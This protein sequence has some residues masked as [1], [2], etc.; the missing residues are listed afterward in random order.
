MLV[1]ITYSD[2]I[3][4]FQEQGLA[5]G[6]AMAL[7]AVFG[8]G[9]QTYKTDQS[10]R[11]SELGYT[12]DNATEAWMDYRDKGEVADRVTDETSLKKEVR[13]FVRDVLLTDHGSGEVAQFL[14]ASSNDDKLELAE[15]VYSDDPAKW[16][17]F[18]LDLMESKRKAEE[19]MAAAYEYDG[20]Q[21]PPKYA[22]ISD[23]LW[24]KMPEEMQS[25]IAE[26]TA[27]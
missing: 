16:R 12:G 9:I 3:E 22:V 13:S 18:V 5:K 20:L 25:S 26:I 19:I 27:Q 11:T 10:E 14:R 23:D 7:L 24:D 17:E 8:A 21:N 2:I 6:A 15:S 4:A 1:P